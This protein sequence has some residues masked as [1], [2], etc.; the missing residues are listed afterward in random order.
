MVTETLQLHF[1]WYSLHIPQHPE[2][3]PNIAARHIFYAAIVFFYFFANNLLLKD[4]SI[5]IVFAQRLA[6]SL[7]YTIVKTGNP[8]K[9]KSRGFRFWL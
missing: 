8:D 7:L 9:D 4:Y 2:A 1:S 3:P 5:F 6:D